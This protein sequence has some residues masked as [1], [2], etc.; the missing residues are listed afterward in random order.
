MRDRRLLVISR[1]GVGPPYAGNRS[2]MAAEE[3]W[4]TRKAVDRWIHVFVW[5]EGGR[6]LLA[7]RVLQRLGGAWQGLGRRRRPG[8]VPALSIGNRPLDDWSHPSWLAEARRLL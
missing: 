7:D 6:R 4:E 5:P 1:I 3:Q 2:R 8:R